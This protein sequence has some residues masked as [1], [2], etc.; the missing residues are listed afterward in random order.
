MKKFNITGVL[1]KIQFLGGLMK[2][3]YDGGMNK[4]G[5]LTGQ[6]ADLRK[7]FGKKDGGGVAEVPHISFHLIF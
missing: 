1:R 5:G 6:F 4:K 7:G 3:Q 2:K